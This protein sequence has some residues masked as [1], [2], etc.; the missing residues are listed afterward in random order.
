M[1]ITAEQVR[2]QLPPVKIADTA[3]TIHQGQTA[4]RYN[5][6]AAVW[7]TDRKGI[8]HSRPYAWQTIADA[9][10]DDKPLTA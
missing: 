3:G 6:F 7:W 9:I 5:R 8:T 2:D 4:G 1:T 10:N